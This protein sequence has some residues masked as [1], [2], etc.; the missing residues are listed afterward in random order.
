MEGYAVSISTRS[1]DGAP[2]TGRDIVGVIAGCSPDSAPRSAVP[3]S[4]SSGLP[5]IGTSVATV[6]PF[7]PRVAGLC[8]SLAWRCRGALMRSGE[9][10]KWPPALLARI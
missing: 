2:V 3:T 9:T 7:S 6:D 4:G 8:P 5:A 10:K 1:R